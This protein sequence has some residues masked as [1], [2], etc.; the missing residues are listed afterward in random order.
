MTNISFFT[1]SDKYKNESTNEE[2]PVSGDIITEAGRSKILEK[3]QHLVSLKPSIAQEISDAKDNGGIEENEEFSMA[4]DKLTR[5]EKDIAD[6]TRVAETYMVAPIPEAGTYDEV[7]FGMHVKILNCDND[8]EVTYQILGEYES[9]PSNGIISHKSPLG[10]EL[11][12]CK[13]G[14]Y[15]D[16][17]RGGDYIEY[18][19]LEIF[20]K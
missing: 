8:R 4:L 6:L 16:I 7:K 12:G 14:D 3:I 9:D 10:N 20:S 18:E 15:V 11:I 17:P 1:V 2:I 19:V 5:L 13:V